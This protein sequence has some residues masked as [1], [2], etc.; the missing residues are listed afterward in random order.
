MNTE[1][2][3][4]QDS[5]QSLSGYWDVG[6][7]IYI[8]ADLRGQIITIVRKSGLGSPQQ[9]IA[10]PLID[11]TS[12]QKLAGGTNWISLKYTFSNDSTTIEVVGGGSAGFTQLFYKR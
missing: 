12:E 7:T 5:I 10:V 11:G 1:Y 3:K 4:N 6:S 2:N 9:A 8:P